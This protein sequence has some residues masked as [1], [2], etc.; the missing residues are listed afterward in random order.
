[1]TWNLEKKMLLV[2]AN[3]HGNLKPI[4]DEFHLLFYLET[5]CMGLGCF[6]LQLHD[7]DSSSEVKVSDPGVIQFPP[8]F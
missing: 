6:S 3:N 7:S 1:M 4:Y 8:S 5:S 2:L